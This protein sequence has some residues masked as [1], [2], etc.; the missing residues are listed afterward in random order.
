MSEANKALVRRWFKEV[1]ND[2]R[3]AAIDEM[4]AADSVVHGLG[5]EMRGVDAFKPFHA[6]YRDAFP[7]VQITVEA[8]IAEGDMVAAR[9]SATGTHRGDGLGF[10]AT[11]Q[12]AHFTGMTMCRVRNGKLVEGWNTFD[13]LGMMQQLGVV[14]VSGDW[15]AGTRYRI[16][17]P[18]TGPPWKKA[19]GVITPSFLNTTPSFI[20]NCTC[21]ARRCRRADCRARR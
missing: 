14:Q 17:Q 13:Q 1:W 20:T 11:H 9:W 10:P 5:D 16:R 2:G 8:V 15:S 6:A 12:R 3:A 7:D 19:S 21:A 4:L 18:F